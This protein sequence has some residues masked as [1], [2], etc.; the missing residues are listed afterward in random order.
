MR[1]LV[2]ARFEQGVAKVLGYGETTA[3]LPL[4]NPFQEGEGAE[5]LHGEILQQG[6]DYA[7]PEAGQR[8]R[9]Q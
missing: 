4:P 5:G 1:R 7:E 9:L 3:H 8:T 6:G 2:W